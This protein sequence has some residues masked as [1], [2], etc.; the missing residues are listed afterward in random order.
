VAFIK[1]SNVSFRGI[2][3]CVPKE[4]EENRTLPFYSAGEAEQ[5]I[6]KIG[7][8]RKH[9]APKS[10]AVSDLC[11]HAAEKLLTDLGWEKGSVDLLAFCTQCP[12]YLNH[13]TSFV[14]HDRLGLSESTMCLDFFHG[15]PGWVVSLS[16]V[17]N[18][19]S[20]G[21]IK[22]AILLDGD[23]LARTVN[24]NNREEK[25]LFGDAG[26]ATALEFNDEANPIYFNFGTKSDDGKALISPNG[27]WRNPFTLDTLKYELD[28][29][30]GKLSMDQ[31]ETKM[32]SMDIFS[33][34]ITKIPKALKR[35]CEN[36]EISL[37]DVDKLVLHQ[38]NKLILEQIAKRMKI[39]MDKVPLG[40]K[41]Y[42]NTTSAS[43]P[44]SI[45]SE[46]KSEA[47]KGLLRH[48]VCG[49]GT[50]LAW[51]AAYFETNKIVC[52]DVVEI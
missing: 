32:D 46:C 3:A 30:A 18:L 37:D 7:I 28:K 49:F 12:D 21:Q 35:L 10:V 38:A 26:T 34:A 13:P 44:L 22:R 16:S 5:V 17:C 6:E 31:L 1:V 29:I 48:L 24:K 2:T 9:V 51:G 50:G 4:T 36:Y 8:E 14:V 40:L 39:P 47:E 27:G 15:C 45:V 20:S 11:F 41:N 19:L 42:G 52:S 43:I 23:V 25:P 33:F